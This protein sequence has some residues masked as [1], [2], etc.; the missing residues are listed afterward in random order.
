MLQYFQPSLNYHLSL[1]SLFCLF[2][3]DRLILSLPKAIVVE[4]TVHCQAPLQS[5]FKGTVDSCLLLNVIRGAN[6]LFFISKCSGDIIISYI[7]DIHNFL[8]KNG[9]YKNVC[10]DIRFHGNKKY[11]NYVRGDDIQDALSHSTVI[12]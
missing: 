2:L 3:S 11:R 12:F 4:L 9:S 1:R 5:Q 8:Y 7:G 10:N 6:L